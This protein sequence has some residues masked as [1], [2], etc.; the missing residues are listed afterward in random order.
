MSVDAVEAFYAKMPPTNGWRPS[1]APQYE[2]VPPGTVILTRDDAP[3]PE[4]GVAF[5][6]IGP[7]PF[8][9]GKTGILILK[10]G[11]S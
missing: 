1:T 10:Y 6:T 3:R 4:A 2:K 5:V 8:W 11:P 7:D 9:P